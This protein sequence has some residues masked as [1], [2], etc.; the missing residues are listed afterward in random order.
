MIAS[1]TDRGGAWAQRCSRGLE[2]WQEVGHVHQ[3]VCGDD[4]VA[5]DALLKAK[6][7]A[8]PSLVNVQPAG[9]VQKTS[10]SHEPPA[11]STL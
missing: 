9:S 5:A 3:D 8:E 1:R 4:E 7:E 2:E 6:L 11:T 10:S